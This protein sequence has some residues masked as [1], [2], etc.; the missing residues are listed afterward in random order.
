MVSVIVPFWNSEKWI[1]RCCESLTMQQ[2]DLEFILVD[3][4]S[5]DHGSDIVSDYCHKDD[6][7]RLMLNTRTKGVSGARNTGLDYAQ[8]EWITF[9]DADDEML[10]GASKE[11]EKLTRIG[12]NIYQT[13]HVRYLASKNRSVNH[14]TSE[15]WRGLDDLPMLWV[16]VWNKLFRAEFLRDI[17]FDESLQYGEDG[18]F[19][20]ECLAKDGRIYCADKSVMA[21][22]HR[23]ENSGSLSHVKRDTDV[24]RFI[25]AYEEFMRDKDDA[26]K[27]LVCSEL[28]KL[29]ARV[30]KFYR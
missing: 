2:G 14:R 3:D 12:A 11:L 24:I 20:L 25:H 9:L 17:R 29:W 7:F 1:G 21:V 23:I 30:E 16:G 13:G 19:M 4:H 8:G 6:R 28:V 18:L 22:R 15:G 26:V 10:P 27:A 5:T